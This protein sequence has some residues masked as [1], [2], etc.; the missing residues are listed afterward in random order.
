MISWC[1]NKL[2]FY[3]SFSMFNPIWYQLVGNQNQ[4]AVSAVVLPYRTFLILSVYT[5]LP[6]LSCQ[7]KQQIKWQHRIK[8]NIQ[9]KK[10]THS[11]SCSLLHSSTLIWTSPKRVLVSLKLY[12]AHIPNGWSCD[13]LRCSSTEGWF[14]WKY[15]INLFLQEL[16]ISRANTS[17]LF[18]Q[19]IVSQEVLSQTLIPSGKATPTKK[20]QEAKAPEW[21]LEWPTLHQDPLSAPV[22]WSLRRSSRLVFLF[23]FIA[24]HRGE[25]ILEI[26]QSKS[27]N[28]F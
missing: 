9:A 2:G 22:Q 23:C 18:N 17:K 8:T 28:F 10:F 1:D 4:V 27:P 21:I 24:S 14:H 15:I 26:K 7:T 3:T 5:P 20:Q 16:G 13:A 19:E 25:I 11:E 6:V 12:W